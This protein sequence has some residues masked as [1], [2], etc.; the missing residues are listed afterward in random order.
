MR[1]RVSAAV[2]GV[3]LCAATGCGADEPQSVDVVRVLED[4]QYYY[5]CGNEV[6][7]LTDGQ[8]LYPLHPDE[9]ADVDDTAYDIA[10]PAALGGASVV[11]VSRW[12][13]VAPGPGDDTGTLTIYADGMA[14]W[15]SDTGIE[16][17]LS[18]T[19]REYNWVC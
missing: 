13:V 5:A 15:V 3:V 7:V 16:A 8:K 12:T 1:R 11:G 18:E 6:L 10:A 19:P 17:W 2:L 9:Q 14:H 4:Q